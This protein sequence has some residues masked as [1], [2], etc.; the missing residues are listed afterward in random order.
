MSN[1]KD[2]NYINSRHMDEQKALEQTETFA[3]LARKLKSV[4]SQT[5]ITTGRI[6]ESTRFPA[7]KKL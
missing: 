4:S 5:N 6:A 1:R 7:M 3:K 2:Q